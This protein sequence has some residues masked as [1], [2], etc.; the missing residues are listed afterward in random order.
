MTS[1]QRLVSP[2]WGQK[3]KQKKKKKRKDKT[4]VVFHGSNYQPQQQK[5]S[6]TEQAAALAELDSTKEQAFF[7]VMFVVCVY[8]TRYD[9]ELAVDTGRIIPSI[10]KN[11]IDRSIHP[12][13][14]RSIQPDWWEGLDR[15]RRERSCLSYRGEHL[16]SPGEVFL[17]V[18]HQPLPR[19]VHPGGDQDDPL[20]WWPRGGK[21]GDGKE[22]GVQ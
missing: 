6:M 1:P 22:C 17:G 19:V 12:S 16:K 20:A 4:R 3:T 10:G 9:G 11:S 8:G 18:H 2:A 15:V 21:G 5:E 13:T 7:F 14:H